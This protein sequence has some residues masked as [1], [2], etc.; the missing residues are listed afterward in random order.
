MHLIR[1]VVATLT[2]NLVVAFIGFKL[3]FR[4]KLPESGSLRSNMEL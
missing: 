4:M 2:L 1:L 3:S